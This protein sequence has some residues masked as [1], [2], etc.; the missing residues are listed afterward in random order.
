MT[1]STSPVKSVALAGAA[2]K[3]SSGKRKQG[4]QRIAASRCRQGSSA[5]PYQILRHVLNKSVGDE[6]L[7]LERSSGGK[8]QSQCQAGGKNADF[9][10]DVAEIARR[11]AKLPKAI[12]VAILAMVKASR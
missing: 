8:S 11:W 9:P 3:R 4:A 2:K 6:G 7:E 1:S 10:K 5:E 12:K